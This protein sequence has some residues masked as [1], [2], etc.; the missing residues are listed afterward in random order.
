MRA[1]LRVSD[2]LNMGGFATVSRFRSLQT[3]IFKI[4]GEV[5]KMGKYCALIK[6]F[7]GTDPDFSRFFFWGQTPIFPT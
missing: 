4:V 7:L 3:A 5:S 2:P 1:Q 6:L